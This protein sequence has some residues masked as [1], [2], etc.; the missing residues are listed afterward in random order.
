[1]VERGRAHVGVI[2][3]RTLEIEHPE[4]VAERIR[5]VL[6]HI[7]PERVTRL[8][9]QPTGA[10]PIADLM[11][12]Y[13]NSPDARDL[14]YQ[15]DIGAEASP[16]PVP[17]ENQPGHHPAE[18]Q[19]KPDLDK[20]AAKLGTMEP[21]ERKD[22]LKDEPPSAVNPVPAQITAKRTPER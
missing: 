22:I 6:K 17:A 14:C 15:R 8:P 13:F 4:Q 5:K 10:N 18:E 21:E 3:V 9:A 11:G 1:M 7:E 2:D 16:G 12:F 20:F 19:D